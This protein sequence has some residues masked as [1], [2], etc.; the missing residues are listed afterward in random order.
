MMK[1]YR[2]PSCNRDT[3]STKD[4]YFAGIW[5]VIYCPSCG[6]RLC[7]QPW[8]LA[9]G[10]AIYVWAF[11]WFGALAFFNHSLAP[12]VYLVPVWLFLDFLNIRFMPLAVMRAK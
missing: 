4:K 6:A 10:W 11:M 2:C 5:R 8:L 9:L 7:A 3:I 12:L 1:S